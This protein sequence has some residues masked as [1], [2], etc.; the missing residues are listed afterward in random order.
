MKRYSALLI[1]LAGIST[2]ARPKWHRA[3]LKECRAETLREEK[4]MAKAGIVGDA[5]ITLGE[6]MFSN[7]QGKGTEP[8]GYTDGYGHFRIRYVKWVN[9][10][11]IEISEKEYHQAGDK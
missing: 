5:P 11:E 9:G 8:C 3:T 7:G 4:E 2:Y 1:V 10:K 6:V